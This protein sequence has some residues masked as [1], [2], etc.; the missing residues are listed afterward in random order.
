MKTS[1]DSKRSLGRF[2]L[3]VLRSADYNFLGAGVPPTIQAAGRLRKGRSGFGFRVGSLEECVLLS[4]CEAQ[5][6]YS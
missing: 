3:C 5:S 4:V 1:H 2:R 6:R